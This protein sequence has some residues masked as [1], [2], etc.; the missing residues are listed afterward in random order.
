[1]T[2]HARPRGRTLF[3]RRQVVRNAVEEFRTVSRR[4]RQLKKGPR[5]GVAANRP[6]WSAHAD[7]LDA[8]HAQLCIRGHQGIA[9]LLTQWH[10]Y[11]V[12]ARRTGDRQQMLLAREVSRDIGRAIEEIR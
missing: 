9:Q 11:L 4:M 3:E 12:T 5:G 10:A 6:L 1:V 2:I 8:V 7:Q